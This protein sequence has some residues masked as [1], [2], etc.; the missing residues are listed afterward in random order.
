MPSVLP[1]D[2]KMLESLQHFDIRFNKVK[3]KLPRSML[4]L[5]NLMRLN[6]RGNGVSEINM[7]DLPYLE[8]LNCS[9]NSLRSLALNEGPITNLTAKNNRK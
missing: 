3:P 5:R 4:G 9:D 8:V 1:D 7:A 2:I 6:I